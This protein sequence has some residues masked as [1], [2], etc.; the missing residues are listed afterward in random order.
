MLC[1]LIHVSLSLYMCHNVIS[2]LIFLI[3][4]HYSLILL[5]IQVLVAPGSPKVILQM[6][7]GNLEAF[8]PRPLIL[9]KARGIIDASVCVPSMS[10]I[11]NSSDEISLANQSNQFNQ[12]IILASHPS[13]SSSSSSS[14]LIE[15]LL[16]LRRQKVD[17]NYL[18]DY[19]PLT[20]LREVNSLVIKSVENNPDILSLLIS[21]LQ[22]GDCTIFKYPFGV[23]NYSYNNDNDNN[24]NNNTNRL[25]KL[26]QSDFYEGNNKV[27]VI[28]TAI[29]TALLPLLQS[30]QMNALNPSLCTYAKQKPPLLVEALLLIREVSTYTIITTNTTPATSSITYNTT[31]TANNAQQSKQQ[32]LSSSKAQNAIKY[33]AFLAEGSALFDAAL[34]T[35]YCMCCCMYCCMYC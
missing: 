14:S 7:R 10:S 2:S 31:D 20:F 30:G 12:A 22:G 9:L 18:I 25:L 35:Y 32:Q 1:I 23:N 13:T 3:F 21:S 16:L 19:N 28:C 5:N 33:L 29:R 34:G 24:N 15:C 11:A 26:P 17:L 6:P 4:L 8:E 27:N